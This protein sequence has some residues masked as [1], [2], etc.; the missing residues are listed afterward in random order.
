MKKVYLTG[1]FAL[2]FLIT[3][4]CFA[5]AYADADV[6][7][8]Q[9][10]V[11]L[12]QL[13]E[14]ELASIES[15]SVIGYRAYPG[16]YNGY[17]RTDEKGKIIEVIAVNE[18]NGS[19]ESFPNPGAGKNLTMLPEM[20]N[21]RNL[22]LVRPTLVSL[23]GTDRLPQLAT[24][25]VSYASGLEDISPIAS[26][27]KLEQ[28]RL[29]GTSVLS[30]NGIEQCPKLWNITIV[31]SVKGVKD[32]SALKQCN[33]REAYRSN[34]V[35]LEIQADQRANFAAI[36]S[37]REYAYFSLTGI[38]PANYLPRIQ[39]AIVH[40]LTVSNQQTLSLRSL[41][42]VLDRL[43][44]HNVNI[45]DLTGMRSPAPETVQ[46]DSMLWLNS[47]KGTEKL[48]GDGGI[49]VLQIG[50][51]P[52][53]KDWGTLSQ[54]ESVSLRIYGDKVII[55]EEL[56]ARAVAA[57]GEGERWM[58]DGTFT[59]ASMQELKQLTEEQ[60]GLITSL[61][62]IG[63]AIYDSERYCPNSA[64]NEKTK[65]YV[66]SVKDRETG[67]MT[68]V[69]T[70]Q[71]K[72]L[73]VLQGMTSLKSLVIA[74]IP[75][76]SLSG[77]EVCGQL[78]NLDIYQCENLEDITAVSSLE[79]LR[80]LTLRVTKVSSLDAVTPLKHLRSLSVQI[81]PFKKID[82][83]KECDFSEALRRENGF[84]LSLESTLVIRDYSAL[85]SISRYNVLSLG[86]A[87]G[88]LWVPAVE[89]VRIKRLE[90]LDSIQLPKQLRALAEKHNEI[91]SM[92]IVGN[93]VRDLTPLLTMR[94]LKYVQV[95]NFMNRAVRS[96]DHQPT[97]AF[98]LD[99]VD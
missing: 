51:C 1:L 26:L 9:N 91:E 80:F 69:R 65:K 34:G 81:A 72:D 25:E 93:D 78:D 2:L 55:P 32:F 40:V 33:F 43:E 6:L 85:A 98:E 92:V 74:G 47:L 90:L 4:A 13:S 57:D 18:Q 35:Y 10:V 61:T 17:C 27:K 68:Q 59:V 31:N 99:I 52:R 8:G 73:S 56:A 87:D 54:A 22:R 66:L 58:A 70:G 88:N 63:D 71:M 84:S 38:S 20:P 95:P 19:T 37:V 41:P 48:F 39:N 15:M 82:F 49:K 97:M 23:E 12:K 53:L 77:I 60:R 96:L 76:T 94:G 42:I 75:I 45:K 24:L 62:I 86:H 79:N 89:G 5:F 50:G 16:Y 21:L 30:L 44:L 7:H 83:L 36:D 29:D 67:K 11:D 28:I 64:W 14:E 3:A 46:L